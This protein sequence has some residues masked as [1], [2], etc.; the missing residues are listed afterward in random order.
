MIVTGETA[1]TSPRGLFLLQQT[2]L[3]DIIK[4]V[5]PQFTRFSDDARERALIFMNKHESGRQGFSTSGE[6]PGANGTGSVKISYIAEK[7]VP[8]LIPEYKFISE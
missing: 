3:P 1:N 6:N 7:G 4:V 8:I 5:Y 2:E